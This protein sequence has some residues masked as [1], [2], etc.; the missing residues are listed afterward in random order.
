MLRYAAIQY[1]SC[2]GTFQ[3][4]K[5][6]KQLYHFKV[7]SNSERESDMKMLPILFFLYYTVFVILF[8]IFFL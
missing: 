6:E 8:C 7:L 1:A 4:C 3:R 2:F 5:V